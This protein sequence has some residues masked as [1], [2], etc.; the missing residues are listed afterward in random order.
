MPQSSLPLLTFSHFPWILKAWVNFQSSEEEFCF[1]GGTDFYWSFL[2]Q[3]ASV[4]L[5]NKVFFF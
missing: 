1:Y 4:F 3:S 5:I 2:H